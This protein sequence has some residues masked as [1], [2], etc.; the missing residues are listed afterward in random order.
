MAQTAGVVPGLTLAFPL[1]NATAL[2]GDGKP[3]IQQRFQNRDAHAHVNVVGNVET[4][5]VFSVSA[6]PTGVLGGS[7]AE[8]VK[9]AARLR[10]LH[11]LTLLLPERG[12]ILL[13]LCQLEL[14]TK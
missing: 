4:G 10:G 7:K 5:A 1:A 14:S 6:A 11:E 3:S 13:E 2:H 8:E 12:G 9:E